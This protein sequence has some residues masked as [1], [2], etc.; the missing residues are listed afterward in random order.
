[1]GATSSKHESTSLATEPV[2]KMELGNALARKLKEVTPD[3]S[4]P[5]PDAKRQEVIDSSIQEKIHA[6]LSKLRKQEQD[7]QKKIELALEKENIERQGKPWFG[8]DKGQSSE[9]LQQELNRVKEQIEKFNKRSIDSFPALKKA[10][11]DIIQ[12]YR[13]DTKRTLD[14]WREVDAFKKAIAD[15][16]KEL[17]AAW[18]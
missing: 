14:C 1:M 16:E 4:A 7:M 15:A 3:A 8:K 12:C 17:F 18:K 2:D 11:E 10:R 5:A 9:L 6:E 13:N